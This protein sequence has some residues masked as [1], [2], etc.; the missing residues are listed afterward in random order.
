M[1]GLAQVIGLGVN[2]GLLSDSMKM[3]SGASTMSFIIH[4]GNK[5]HLFQ[6]IVIFPDKAS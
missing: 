2:I 1:S 3:Q 4:H 6:K 5:C